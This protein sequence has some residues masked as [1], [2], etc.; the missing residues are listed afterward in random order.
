M[1]LQHN[2]GDHGLELNLEPETLKEVSQLFRFANNAKR[3]KPYVYLSFN[4]DTPYLNIY[5]RKK[6]GPK[7]SNT[8]H[9]S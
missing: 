4:G 8:V 9:P 3:E 6:R 1:K 2:E 7:V 5:M